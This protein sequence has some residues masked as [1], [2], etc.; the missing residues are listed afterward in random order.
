PGSADVRALRRRRLRGPHHPRRRPPVLDLRRT[1]NLPNPHR[2]PQRSRRPDRCRGRRNPPDQRREQITMTP[3]PPSPTRLPAL[4]W[5]PLWTRALDE[6]IGI[7]F[8]ITGL[9]RETFCNRL[10][11]CRDLAAAPRLQH[12]VMF[13]T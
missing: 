11:E 3:R 13:L 6:E 5:L 4:T 9:P 2:A 10:Y 12:M 1:P 8:T 7:R